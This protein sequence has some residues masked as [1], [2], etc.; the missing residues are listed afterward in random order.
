[1]IVI[2]GSY[3]PTRVDVYNIDGWSRELPQLNTGRWGHGCGQY[4]NTNDKIV[5]YTT[6]NNQYQYLHAQVYLV[7]GGLDDNGNFLSSTETLVDGTGSWTFAGQLPV[8]MWGLRGV[9]LNNDIFMTGN[10]ITH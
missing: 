10:I 1:M 6:G 9:S 3:N 7:T 5:N 4:I 8:A 2:G